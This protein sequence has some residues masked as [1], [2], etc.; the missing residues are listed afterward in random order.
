M[1][2]EAYLYKHAIE[3]FWQKKMDIIGDTIM[4]ALMTDSYV[5]NQDDHETWAGISALEHG[6]GDG[7]LT[8][9]KELE[10]KLISYDTD[11]HILKFDA[12]DLVWEDITFDD[13]GFAVIYDSTEGYLI[14]YVDF[15][16][17]VEVTA[18]DFTLSWNING[19]FKDTIVPG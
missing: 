18:A 11:T 4:A 12:A 6:N 3:N 13:V 17:T 9:G 2:V 19:I 14:G 5:P 1:T 8:G 16:E 10:D 15:D 7:Y